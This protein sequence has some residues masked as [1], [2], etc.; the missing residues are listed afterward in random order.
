[1]IKVWL[2]K[3]RD[4]VSLCQFDEARDAECVIFTIDLLHRF[5]E[6]GDTIVGTSKVWMDQSTKNKG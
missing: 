5:S 3:A 6:A 1:M 4:V 2:D